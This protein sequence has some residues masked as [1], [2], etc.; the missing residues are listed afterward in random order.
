MR[1]Q[2]ST[3]CLFF[4][5]AELESLFAAINGENS[6]DSKL[7]EK[8]AANPLD[9]KVSWRPL[10]WLS[11]TSSSDIFQ[12]MYLPGQRVQPVA[13]WKVGKN[14]IHLIY[15][16]WFLKSSSNLQ[17]K[18]LPYKSCAWSQILP[19]VTHM[20]PVAIPNL[21]EF[22]VRSIPAGHPSHLNPP[23]V[24]LT[25]NPGLWKRSTHL[26]YLSILGFNHDISRLTG[27]KTC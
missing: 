21:S 1:W 8:R 18:K 25:T 17:A 10:S 26:T 23:P 11:C 20:S 3:L 2:C 15:V 27:W 5:F 24:K 13:S 9:Q 4:D 22:V 16:K 12:I 6:D 14:N 19:R 7:D